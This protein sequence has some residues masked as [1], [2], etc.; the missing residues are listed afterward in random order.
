MESWFSKANLK[1]KIAMFALIAGV[2]TGLCG[3]NAALFARYGYISGP[4]DPARSAGLSM[5]LMSTGF[6]ELIGI[7]I[8]VIGLL[9]SALSLLVL[10]LY[11]RYSSSE[12]ND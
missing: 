1:K 6:C 4:N 9:F 8:G 5:V 10:L 3:T 11:Q 2:S 12:A 7:V